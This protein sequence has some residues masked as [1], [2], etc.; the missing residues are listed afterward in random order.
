MRVRVYVYACVRACVRAC[1]DQM[2]VFF[3]N[4]RYMNNTS[5]IKMAGLAITWYF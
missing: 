3:H 4:C 5:H 1:V 2:W